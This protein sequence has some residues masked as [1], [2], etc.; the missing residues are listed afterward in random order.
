MRMDQWIAVFGDEEDDQLDTLLNTSSSWCDGNILWVPAT[1]QHNDTLD[2]SSSESSGTDIECSPQA[3]D[4]QCVCVDC[5]RCP[6]HCACNYTRN[7]YECR[8][9]TSTRKN[10]RNRQVREEMSS[11]GRAGPFGSKGDSSWTAHFASSSSRPKKRTSGRTFMA[12]PSNICVETFIFE[13]AD[14]ETRPAKGP[15]RLIS[16]QHQPT[17]VRQAA[18]A[19]IYDN[20]A[21][22]SRSSSQI[23]L[24][25]PREIFP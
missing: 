23:S 3:C 11:H 19:G 25:R 17:D 21:F 9:I 6:H 5:L 1:E 4:L 16:Q 20:E 13:T 22:G 12:V 18:V 10:S 14:E 24:L 2:Y 15:S 8:D 7:D